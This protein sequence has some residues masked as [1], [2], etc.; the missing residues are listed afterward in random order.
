M[1]PRIPGNDPRRRKANLLPAE[2]QTASPDPDAYIDVG[3]GRLIFG[4][5]FKNMADLVST[6]RGE[7]EEMRDIAIY[8]DDPHVALAKAPQEIFLD[9]SHTYRLYL[10]HYK[11]AKESI[12]DIIIRPL[13]TKA[14]AQAINNIYSK[15][16]MVN[17][18]IDFLIA[19]RSSRRLIYLVAE[20]ANSGE[21]IGTVMGVDHKRAYADPEH[22]TSLWCLAVDPQCRM[23]G[24]GE[25]LVRH[26]VEHYQTRGRAFL[27]LS[28]MHD[29]LP[30]LKLYERLGFKRIP[31][32]TLKR[33]NPLNEKLFTAPQPG[34]RLNPYAQ[35][36]INE[37]LKRGI[38]VDVEDEE[39]NLFALSFGGRRIN[40]RESLSDLTSAVALQRCDDK[41]LTHRLLHKA[42]ISVPEQMEVAGENS[43]PEFLARHDRVVVKPVKGEQGAGIT[44][45]ISGQE[46]V[47]AAIAKAE[48]VC[49]RVLL[50]QFCEG[51]DLRIIVIDNRVV[52]AAVRRPASVIGDGRSTLKVLI[53]KQS[54]RRKSATGGESHIPMDAETERCLSIQGYTFDSILPEGQHLDVRKTANLHTGGTIHDVTARL[55]LK[56]VEAAAKAAR[57]LEMPVVGF[58]FLVPRVDGPDY[59]IIEANERPGLANHEPQPTAERFVD[60]LFPQTVSPQS[61]VPQ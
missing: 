42:G 4:N 16:K 3:W 57:T 54:R 17:V 59:V 26:L 10:Q 44:V 24:V 15:H 60:L 21:V 58:D 14:D 2:A 29:N 23:P 28:V 27:D 50:E 22:G 8:V 1:A 47:R 45:D 53:E 56:L 34:T 39:A 38:K 5:T 9:P 49:D 48:Q 11:R 13:Q 52:A 20:D 6:L 55:H 36:I 40:C 41:A 7:G 25:A 61:L 51:Q 31:T 32:F 43:V 30:A 46:E 35:I 19:N 12:R 18:A 33:K 37:A